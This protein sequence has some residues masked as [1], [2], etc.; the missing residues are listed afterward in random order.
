MKILVPTD[1]SPLAKA[2]FL[3]AANLSVALKAKLI[4]M[5]AFHIDQATRSL[6]EFT[7]DEVIRKRRLEQENECA[8]HLEEIRREVQ[9]EFVAEYAVEDNGS[10]VTT[11]NSFAQDHRCDLIVMGTKG[12]SGL[13]KALL[14]TN[15]AGVINDSHVPVLVIPEFA[16][17]KGIKDV[18]Y[19][20][21]MNNLSEE[22]QI[23]LPLVRTFDATVHI[24]HM[25]PVGNK[26]ETDEAA[27]SASL[28][29]QL[30]YAKIDCHYIQ[31]ADVKGG[32]EQYLN[33]KNADILA[34]FSGKRNF[35]ERIFE[36]SNTRDVAYSSMVPL[37]TFS[38][39]KS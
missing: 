31:S 14:G 39:K 17:Y 20:S 32:I 15:T 25:H 37:L 7:T 36:K 29:G 1:F 4:L 19:A 9:G 22:L 2:A 24:L 35:F 38:K 34:M 10:V 33:G 26:P 3:Y 23:L 6:A 12:A 5:N 16:I 27:T 28:R 8:R 30:D 18:V 11:I 21:D 13:K